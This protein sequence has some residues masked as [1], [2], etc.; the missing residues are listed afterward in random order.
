MLVLRRF[1]ELSWTVLLVAVRLDVLCGSE[2]VELLS[3]LLVVFYVI[4]L[5]SVTFLI[6]TLVF[7]AHCCLDIL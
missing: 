1:L 2:Q 3:G 6:Q 5:N 7:R 4:F